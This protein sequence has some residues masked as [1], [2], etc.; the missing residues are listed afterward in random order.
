M[1]IKAKN[2][3]VIEVADDDLAKRALKQG[4]E[5]FTSNPRGKGA[6]KWDPDAEPEGDADAESDDE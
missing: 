5:V 3:N 4:H 1:F 2:G 6:K